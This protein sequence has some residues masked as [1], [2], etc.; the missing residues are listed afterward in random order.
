MEG[1]FLLTFRTKNIPIKIDDEAGEIVD[2][3]CSC[4]KELS[5]A[6]MKEIENFIQ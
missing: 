6:T 3:H 4:E 2:K 5:Y 1:K